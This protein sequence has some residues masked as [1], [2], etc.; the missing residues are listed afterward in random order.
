MNLRAEFSLFFIASVI[1]DEINQHFLFPL[2]NIFLIF[3][4]GSF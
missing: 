1:I 2:L 3:V 4:V